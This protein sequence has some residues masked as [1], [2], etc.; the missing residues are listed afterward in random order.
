MHASELCTLIR[1]AHLLE[2]QSCKVT[3]AAS[4]ARPSHLRV[5]KCSTAKKSVTHS[6]Q[7][8]LYIQWES[9]N[10][11]GWNL[12]AFARH[13]QVMIALVEVIMHGQDGKL[14]G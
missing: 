6:E 9:G 11:D 7:S 14:L 1:C 5:K 2:I 8:P 12:G 4:G 10:Q 3:E 13:K